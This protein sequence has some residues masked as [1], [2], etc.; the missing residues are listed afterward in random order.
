MQAAV[1]LGASIALA[2]DLRV[3]SAGEKGGFIG[4]GYIHVGMPGDYGGTW[5]A[6]A[7]LGPGKAKGCRGR[8]RG[9]GRLLI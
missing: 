9:R 1:G 5:L 7:L 2:C 6:S 3:A 8:G 4:M